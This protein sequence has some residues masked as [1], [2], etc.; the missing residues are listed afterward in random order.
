MSQTFEEFLRERSGY[1]THI[2]EGVNVVLVDALGEWAWEEAQ[3]DMHFEESLNNYLEFKK[4]SKREKQQ[5]MKEFDEEPPDGNIMYLNIAIGCLGK[6]EI[7]KRF[8]ELP[9]GGTK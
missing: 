5:A 1:P 7:E 4:L 6:K 3:E 9:R 2:N 8:K